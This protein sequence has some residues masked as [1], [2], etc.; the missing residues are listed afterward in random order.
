MRVAR[1]D[2]NRKSLPK[3]A[4]RLRFPPHSKVPAHHADFGRIRAAAALPCHPNFRS[5]P[6]ATARVADTIP[7][8]HLLKING[9]HVI[10]LEQLTHIHKSA[11]GVFI[12]LSGS[13]EIAVTLREAEAAAFLKYIEEK[14]N[15]TL[16]IPASPAQPKVTPPK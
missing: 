16:A 7:P 14:L 6:I 15:H 4:W 3:A 9:E 13:K 10:N 1:A 12:H 8:M 5:V 2:H 11:N